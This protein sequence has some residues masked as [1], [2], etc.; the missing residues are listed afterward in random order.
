LQSLL[1]NLPF[2]ALS[3]AASA[4]D[5]VKVCVLFGAHVG[6]NAVFVVAVSD[7]KTDER[8]LAMKNA[9]FME[10]FILQT[11]EAVVGYSQRSK[12]RPPQ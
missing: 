12:K 10:G 9:L 4:V 7:K 3:D 11:N 5:A 6:C 8:G 1:T 2:T